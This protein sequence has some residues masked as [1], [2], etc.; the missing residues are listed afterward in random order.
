MVTGVFGRNGQLVPRHVKQAVEAGCEIAIILFLCTEETT[1]PASKMSTMNVIQV[2]DTHS[3]EDAMI[4][5]VQVCAFTVFKL[6]F[7]K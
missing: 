7:R 2:A 1:A 5:P 3:S 6:R 4:Y